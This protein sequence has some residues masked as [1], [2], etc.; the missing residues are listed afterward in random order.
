MKWI[1]RCLPI[2]TSICVAVLL[3]VS[4]YGSSMKDLRSLARAGRI[5]ETARVKAVVEV[6]ADAPPTAVWSLLA[7]I[8]GWPRWQP[9]ITK[10]VAPS[11]LAVGSDFDW[12]I[13]GSPIHS[14]VE[15]LEAGHRLVWVSFTLSSWTIHV[16]TLE[17]LPGNKTRIVSA[18]SMDGDKIPL[19]SKELADSDEAWL[20]ALKVAA[21]KRAATGYQ[22]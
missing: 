12:A 3:S 10:A 13:D 17:A 4:A 21:E 1:V 7:D 2:I 22:P 6:V 8:N 9:G 16:W 19:T 14:H 5:H 18:E 15:R 20:N 11:P